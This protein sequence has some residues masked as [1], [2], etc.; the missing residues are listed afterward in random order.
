M[1]AQHLQLASSLSRVCRL[2][3]CHS[4]LTPSAVR[5]AQLWTHAGAAAAAAIVDGVARVRGR[6]SA[7]GCAGHF[8]TCMQ[9]SRDAALTQAAGHITT[10]LL[11]CT[12]FRAVCVYS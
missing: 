3:K 11:A 4:R 5:A 7:I 8:D 12:A 2:C 10:D 1:A 6:C 9:G